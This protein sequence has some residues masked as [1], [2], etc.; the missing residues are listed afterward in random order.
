MHHRSL[1]WLL[2]VAALLASTGA[3]SSGV[4]P[5]TGKLPGAGY[6]VIAIG[7]NGKATTSAARSFRI[8]PPDSRVTLHLR[9]G[10]GKYAGPIVVGGSASRAIIGV[11]AGAKL[12]RIK[13]LGGYGR[14]RVPARLRDA[15]RVAQAVGGVPL[16]NGRNF[17]LVRSTAQ[18]SAGP[19]LDQDGDGVP[20]ALD[21]DA[22]GDLVLNALDRSPASAARTTSGEPLPPTFSNFSQL[23]LTVDQTVNADAA[24]VTDAAIDQ[25]VAD[26]LSL[27]LLNVPAATDLDCGHL[28]YCSAGGTGQVESTTGPP[29]PGT[30][31][32]GCCDADGDG[33]GTMP[34]NATGEFRLDPHATSRQIGSGDTFILRQT[35]D[36]MVSEVAESLNFVF[37]TTPAVQ[38]WQDGSGASGTITYPAAAAAPGTQA[39]PIPLAADGS[40]HYVVTLTLWRPQRRAISDAGEGEGYIDIGGLDYEA[41]VPNVPGRPPGAATSPQCPAAALS[42]ADANLTIIDGPAGGHATDGAPSVPAD[43]ANTLTFTVDLSTCATLKGGTLGSGD[44]LNMDIAANAPSPSHDH[45][46]QIVYVRMQ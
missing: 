2:V 18:S 6:S 12:G 42:S 5:I 39:N 7:Y 31:F 45:A 4:R 13:I 30:P 38:S 27:V 1:R 21:I 3:A 33:I 37:T 26:R 34:L 28:A 9:D 36:G 25:V 15:E 46:N 19:G 44:T 20:D 10:N 23:F 29:G 17:G 43:P 32:P 24:A 11:R 35:S 16:G 41:N 22:N 40:G 8:V 14:A